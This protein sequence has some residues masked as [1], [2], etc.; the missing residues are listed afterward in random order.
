MTFEF[1]I[2]GGNS[3]KNI[4]LTIEG[5]LDPNTARHQKLTFRTPLKMAP[6][7]WNKKRQRPEN[8]YLKKFKKINTKL[9][10]LKVELASYIKNRH[11][12]GK[13]VTHRML[14][15]QIKKICAENQT[16]YPEL[17][18]LYFMQLYI[19]AKKEVI[20]YS[21]YKR[22]RV[23]FHLVEKFEGFIT[24]RLYVDTINSNFLKNFILFGKE[25]M[26]SENTIHRTIHFIRTILNFAERKGIRTAV[27]ELDLKRE[28]QQ[29]EL[30]TL[31]EEEIL[32]IKILPLS[33]KLTPARDWLMIS[34]YTGQRIS[35]FM[36]FSTDKL[37]E[38]NGRAYITFTQKKTKKNILLP[39]H[40]EVINVLKNNGNKFPP[41][42]SQAEY[43]E[44]IKKIA[45]MAG[46]R[47]TVKTRIRKGHRANK[48]LVEKWEVLSS[49][50][51][52]RSFATIFYG[53]IPTPLLMEATGHT[54][55][56]MFLQYINSA[57]MNRASS[58]GDYFEKMENE[59]ELVN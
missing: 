2:P 50:V 49:H 34:C 23:F 38:V 58:L 59:K 26:Y 20:S 53:K 54:T 15:R 18:L 44:C 57:D 30:I 25:E 35:D 4:H 56:R 19:D 55:E 48:T 14:S 32:A 46:I 29:T 45:L 11:H 28:K 5:V 43:N 24:E 16:Q 39:L 37:L 8:I 10:Q 33:G 6:E 12:T 7:H 36:E 42:L 9:D 41:K 40:P 17:S 31:S 51:G 3:A 1:F 27:K 22:Y 21:T 13:T 47:Q 52:R